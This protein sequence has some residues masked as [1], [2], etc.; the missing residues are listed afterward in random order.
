[1][2]IKNEELGIGNLCRSVKEAVWRMELRIKIR[3]WELG[4][5]AVQ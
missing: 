2:G 5:Y 3:N 4:I 1:L